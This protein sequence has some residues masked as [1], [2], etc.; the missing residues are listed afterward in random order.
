MF[1]FVEASRSVLEKRI[2]TRM[3]F[4]YPSMNWKII[5][6]YRVE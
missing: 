1:V 2:E 4:H 3:F 6:K 5:V